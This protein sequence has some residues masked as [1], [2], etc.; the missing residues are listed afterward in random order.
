MQGAS[1][2]SVRQRKGPPARV[3]AR[4]MELARVGGWLAAK[5]YK[6]RKWHLRPANVRARR[7]AFGEA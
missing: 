1:G 4:V 5:Q 2:F 6:D 3:E 7:L